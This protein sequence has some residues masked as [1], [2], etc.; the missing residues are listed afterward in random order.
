MALATSRVLSVDLKAF[1]LSLSKHR[2]FFFSSRRSRKE[3]Q[4]FDKLRA[5]GAICDSSALAGEDMEP[6]STAATSQ[7]AGERASYSARAPA[8]PHRPGSALHIDLLGGNVL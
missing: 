4:P 3:E 5:N 1:V 2:F 7:E 8:P 6:L